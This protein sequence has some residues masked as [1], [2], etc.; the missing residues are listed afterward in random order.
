M[1]SAGLKAVSRTMLRRAGVQRNR[2]GRISGVNTWLF[3]FLLPEFCSEIRTARCA[4]SSLCDFLGHAL[5]AHDTITHGNAITPIY[6]EVQAGK[7]M[8]EGI[9]A[10]LHPAV[11]EPI[12]RNGALVFAH[13]HKVR[14]V[15]GADEMLQFCPG[16]SNELVFALR[17]EIRLARATDKSRQQHP[18][19]R[20]ASGKK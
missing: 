18:I 6:R 15:I 1:K 2:R 13:M 16:D 14:L 7:I 11:R 9:Q 3:P 5:R 17:S 19:S 20:C 10:M 8:L 4:R 12:L